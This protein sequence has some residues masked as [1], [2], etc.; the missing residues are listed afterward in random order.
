MWPDLDYILCVYLDIFVCSYLD[1]CV[2]TCNVLAVYDCI[3]VVYD[4]PYS[5]LCEVI[6]S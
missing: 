4:I 5:L 3:L 1:Y 6:C 2:C